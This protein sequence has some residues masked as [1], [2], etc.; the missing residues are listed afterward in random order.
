M[1]SDH[2]SQPSGTLLRLAGA[3]LV[4]VALVAGTA[5]YLVDEAAAAWLAMVAWTAAG[6]I[7]VGGLRY[8]ARRVVLPQGRRAWGLLAFAALGWLVGQLAYD[9]YQVLGQTPPM[10]SAADVPWLIFAAVAIIALHGFAPFDSDIRYRRSSTVLDVVA[11]YTIVAVLS[12]IVFYERAADSQVPLLTKLT[13]IAYAALFSAA[14]VAFG[15]AMFRRHLLRRHPKLM[16]LGAGLVLQAAGFIM[17]TP[18]LLAGDYVAGRYATDACWTAGMLCL[19]LAGFLAAR[20]E[21]L[22]APRADD[23]RR[24]ALLPTAG[25][26]V[27]LL[28]L[29]VLVLIDASVPVRLILQGGIIVAGV[30]FVWR[31]WLMS[32]FEREADGDARAARDELD[33]FFTLS[34]EML[35]VISLDGRLRR[36]NPAVEAEFGYTAA[37]LASRPLLEF[38]H[39]DDRHGMEAGLAE[40]HRGAERASFDSRLRRR[41]GRY[42][43]LRM[44][45]TPSPEHGVA[46]VVARDLTER[47]NVEIALRQAHAQALAAS[48]MK[49]DFVANMSHEIRTPLNGVVG[50]TELL[51]DTALTHEQGEY[52]DA[53][54]ASGDA[55]LIVINDI[56]DFSKIEAGKLTIEAG[57]F[58]PRR[59]VEEVCTMIAAT[60]GAAGVEV[61]APVDDSCPDTVRGDVAR[62]RQVL[63]N[64]VTNAVKF[65]T[66]GEV[67]VRTA[68]EHRRDDRVWLRVEV[69]DTG[70]GIDPSALDRLFEPFEQADMSTTRK[71][72]GTGLGL[73]ISAQLVE[74]MGGEIG[75]RSELGRGS[76]FW[77]TVPFETAHGS[78][79]STPRPDIEGLRVLVV[80]DNDTNRAILAHQLRSWSTQCDTAVD[81]ERALDMLEAAADAG[82][83][84][85]LVLLDFNMP[86]LDG[87]DVVRAMKANPRLRTTR[88][89]LLTS[90]VERRAARDAGVEGHLTKPVRREQ[91]GAEIRR[92]MSG[93]SARHRETATVAKR[94]VPRA[95]AR[96]L[97]VEDQLINQRVAAGLLE[98]RGLHVDVAADGRQAIEL[99]AAGDY[100][101]IFMDCQMP[102]LDGYEATAEI[103]RREASGERTPIV[104]MTAHALTG[105]RERCLEAGMDDYLSK[106]VRAADIDAVLARFLQGTANAAAS[107]AAPALPPPSTPPVLD[108]TLLGEIC[109][110]DEQARSELSRLFL[111]QAQEGLA[112]LDAALAGAD[113]H[114]VRHVAHALKGSAAM[115]GALRMSAACDA[116]S[117]VHTTDDLSDARDARAQIEHD[118]ALTRRA[119]APTPRRSEMP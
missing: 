55:L 98:K 21:S 101:V 45:A 59:T 1:S 15:Q 7:A 28:L 11:L 12:V 35:A 78:A 6:V 110:G 118:F 63:T 44:S 89:L 104:A 87:G 74:L 64:L 88:V 22:E 117:R 13:A 39:P 70:V 80:D 23:L 58:D 51:R 72:G 83:P 26:L 66:D 113:P 46:Y 25:F 116:L 42:V 27:S 119:F 4:L 95:R 38:I 14:A 75:A 69:A 103:R 111:D 84:Y 24:R 86:G 102:E 29:P 91:L 62:F 36:V 34:S 67:A 96:V 47:N 37:E 99:H 112:D 40:L 20:G 2:P 97:V 82:R 61:V 93:H 60:A 109:G 77:F 10:P 108:P 49:S 65:T 90:S 43:A 79:P 54:R 33:R 94:A 106:P 9:V 57:D 52:T 5:E 31:L 81:G 48:Q 85:E 114:A 68:R 19:G 30:C 73:A 50:M 3:L 17:W 56:L 18:R 16:A 105:D 71:Y 32:R 107:P 92:V 53:I 76:T 41:D 100:A 8:G 115:V